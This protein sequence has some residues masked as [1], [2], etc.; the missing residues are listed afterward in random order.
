MRRRTKRD[1]VENVPMHN[2][3]T[4][5]KATTTPSCHQNTFCSHKN[6]LTAFFEF[7]SC[8][9]SKEKQKKRFEKQQHVV[10]VLRA[11]PTI[12]VV[13]VQRP[14]REDL[15]VCLVIVLDFFFFE[16]RRKKSD[17]KVLREWG[18]FKTVGRPEAL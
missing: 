9:S 4:Q 6:R 2:K 8:V 12:V 17:F 14:R 3:K 5:K 7:A 13:V 15:F 16:R 10:V 18:D 11:T 1:L